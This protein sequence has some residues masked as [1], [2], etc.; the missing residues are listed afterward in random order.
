MIQIRVPEVKKGKQKAGERQTTDFG[1][2][3]AK[4]DAEGETR[5]EE[6]TLNLSQLR[7]ERECEAV[8][9]F[10]ISSCARRK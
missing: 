6:K 8:N 1:E 2:G 10:H 3:E 9:D 4:G 7:K 5:E